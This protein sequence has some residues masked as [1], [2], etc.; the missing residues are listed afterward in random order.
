MSHAL[1]LLADQAALVLAGIEAGS[2]PSAEA[3]EAL[4]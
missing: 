4:R 1:E 3:S 2:G